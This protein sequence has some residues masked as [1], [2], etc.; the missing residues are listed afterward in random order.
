[1]NHH[2]RTKLLLTALLPQTLLPLKTPEALNLPVYDLIRS[3]AMAA[4]HSPR[5]KPT[6]RLWLQEGL[7]AEVNAHASRGAFYAVISATM[8]A[9]L[10]FSVRIRMMRPMTS[11]QLG[12]WMISLRDRLLDCDTIR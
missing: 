3:S 11:L 4:F 10:P 2:Y 5:H 6:V 9:E 8:A 1:M 7:S 12:S